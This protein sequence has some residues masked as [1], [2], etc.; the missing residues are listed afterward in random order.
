M[1]TSL[2]THYHAQ[3]K[4]PTRSIPEAPDKWMP[5]AVDTHGVRFRGVPL[6]SSIFQ[7]CL[8]IFFQAIQDI[9]TDVRLAEYCCIYHLGISYIHRCS[10]SFFPLIYTS[11]SSTVTSGGKQWPMRTPNVTWANWLTLTYRCLSPLC[12][13]G[14]SDQCPSLFSLTCTRRSSLLVDALVDASG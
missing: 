5:F 8:P 6:Y 11:Q 1:F 4:S 3:W 9:S 12:L 14:H 13:P 10:Q 2:I 7:V